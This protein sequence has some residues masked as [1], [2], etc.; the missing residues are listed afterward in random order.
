MG[1]AHKSHLGELFESF[2]PKP[3]AFPFVAAPPHTS[4][5]LLLVAHG[6]ADH[7]APNL[8][9]RRPGQVVIYVARVARLEYAR[10]RNPPGVKTEILVFRRFL[11]PPTV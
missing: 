7:L 5:A 4:G 2:R 10:A 3:L 9:G 6:D 11:P 8:P 1:L